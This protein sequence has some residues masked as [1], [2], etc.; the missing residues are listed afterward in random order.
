[1]SEE[2]AK[3]YGRGLNYETTYSFWMK[4]I[5][6]PLDIIWIGRNK[7]IVDIYPGAL[8]CEDICKGITPAAA[9]KFV[10]EV[11]S[12]F[13]EKNNIKVGDVLTLT[14]I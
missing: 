13:A 11:N 6:F 7:K 14:G 8:P 4:N 5:Q 10:L 2:Q 1:M 9:A 3:W 12:G